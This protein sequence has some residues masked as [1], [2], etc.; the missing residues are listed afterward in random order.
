MALDAEFLSK[1]GIP[2]EHHEAILNGHNETVAGLR[3]DIEHYKNEAEEAT[4]NAKEQNHY[5]IEYERLTAE[6]ESYKT[7]VLKEDA[8]REVLTEL[9]LKDSLVQRLY[10]KPQLLELF[11]LDSKGKIVD[12]YKL[13]SQVLADFGDTIKER[14][15]PRAE[16]NRSRALERIRRNGGI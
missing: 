15:S 7:Q 3:D 5:K 10:N 9:G 2:A 4:K 14:R 8:C 1:A 6:F 13:E 11:D 12:P 16:R